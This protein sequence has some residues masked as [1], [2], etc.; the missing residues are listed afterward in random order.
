MYFACPLIRKQVQCVG[1]CTRVL[2]CIIH[3]VVPSDSMGDSTDSQLWEQEGPE[4]VQAAVQTT[5]LLSICDP[6]NP[7]GPAVSLANWEVIESVAGPD[8]R[9][10]IDNPRVL[11]KFK[12]S[13]Q[14]TGLQ[15]TSCW[16]AVLKQ[17][18]RASESS[19][20]LQDA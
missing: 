8:W 13:Q 2:T 20:W 18:D 17:H 6:A 7:P 14:I 11:G 4:L 1:A 9:T 16:G 12:I 10:R 15:R 5:L 3:L 19:V